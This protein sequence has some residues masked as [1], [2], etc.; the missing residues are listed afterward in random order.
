MAARNSD[1][2]EHRQV[3]FRIGVNVGDVI[4]Y[5]DDLLGDGVNISARL[6]APTGHRALGA[7]G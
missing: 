1:T 2:P 3:C 5:G 6:E 4:A 7:V